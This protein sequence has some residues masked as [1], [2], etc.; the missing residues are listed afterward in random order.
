[1][2]LG[3]HAALLTLPAAKH[4]K[5]F[6]VG[7]PAVGGFVDAAGES[8]SIAVGVF[9]HTLFGVKDGAIAADL[10]LLH[11]QADA[12]LKVALLHQ[13]GQ[14][15]S[16]QISGAAIAG[17]HIPKRELTAKLLLQQLFWALFA[18]KGLQIRP[19][20]EEA[21][22][23]AHLTMTA[24]IRRGQHQLLH[25]I[26][27]LQQ[28]AAGEIAGDAPVTNRLLQ[29]RTVETL[30]EVVLRTGEAILPFVIT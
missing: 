1:M 7:G 12:D 13:P 28:G 19:T 30:Q 24:A 4:I 3:I 14:Q 9:D 26:E 11:W 21:R 22:D 18:A 29:G 20:H 2:L 6:V 10:P 23:Q 5:G 25:P 27:H 16:A 17:L 8:N 15:F